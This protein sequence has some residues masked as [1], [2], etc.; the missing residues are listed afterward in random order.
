MKKHE[1]H[2][3]PAHVDAD[4]NVKYRDHTQDIEICIGLDWAYV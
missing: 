2:C 1:A 3:Q 4:R